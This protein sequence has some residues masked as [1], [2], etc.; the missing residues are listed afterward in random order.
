MKEPSQ[1]ELDRFAAWCSVRYTERTTKKLVSDART[2]CRYDGA[3]PHAKLKIKRLR[4]YLLAWNVWLDCFGKPLPVA[5]PVIPDTSKMRGGRRGREPKRLREAIAFPRAEYDRIVKVLDD[6]DAQLPETVLLV[7]ARTGLRIADV[8][9]IPLAELRAG[10]KR[11]DGIVTITVKG[12]KVSTFS[13]RGVGAEDRAWQRML[14][15]TKR[16]PGTWTIA[17]AMMDDIDASPE[18]GQGAYTRCERALH[19][20]GKEVKATGRVHLHRFRRSVGVY[21]ASAG[22]TEDQIRKVLIH[23][24]VEVTRGYL[25]ESRSYE[26]AQLRGRLLDRKT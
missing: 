19:R 17:A 13:V 24:G 8:L 4:D 23:S 9:R 12:L 22:A 15:L 14:E 20:I 10:R 6:D 11:E 18:A 3:P 16:Y 2:V 21:L 26:S 25:D 5:Q 1:K 7:L